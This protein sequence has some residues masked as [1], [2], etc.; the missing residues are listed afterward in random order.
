MEMS[1]ET[2]DGLAAMQAEIAKMA[3][4]GVDTGGFGQALAE[5]GIEA[6]VTPKEPAAGEE[7]AHLL[8]SRALRRRSVEQQ[9]P[10]RVALGLVEAVHH[11]RA[12]VKAAEVLPG[13]L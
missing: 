12:V 3:S 6:K 9:R 10:D 2:P 4:E 13:R 8:S 11:D 5:A 1:E 7:P